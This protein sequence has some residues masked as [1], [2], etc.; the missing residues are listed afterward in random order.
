MS[1]QKSNVQKY[2][3]ARKLVVKFTFLVGIYPPS[4]LIKILLIDSNSRIECL[5]YK[6]LLG[7]TI[8]YR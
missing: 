1:Y 6:K 5:K 8:R 3:F 2:V 7:K 4:Q